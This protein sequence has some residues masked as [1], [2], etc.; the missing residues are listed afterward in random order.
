M[1]F[2]EMFDCGASSGYGSPGA[3][4]TPMASP[5]AVQHLAN[6]LQQFVM[7]QGYCEGM[8]VAAMNG[9]PKKAT[10]PA[11]TSILRP[12][13]PQS[14]LSTFVAIGL[15]ARLRVGW[16]RLVRK[17]RAARQFYARRRSR[18]HGN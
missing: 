15:P 2:P 7:D 17:G 16:S 5:A 1:G 12:H 14:G 4:G 6:Q 13:S 10:K 8:P 3:I 11:I 18:H 9:T